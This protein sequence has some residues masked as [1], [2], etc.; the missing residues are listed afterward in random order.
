M[1]RTK[2]GNVK[3]VIDGR[4]F[5]SQKEASRYQELK[6]LEAAGEITHL[7]LQPTFVLMDSFT[8]H[9]KKH[10]EI[11]YRADFHYWDNR[12]QIEVVE[13]V[14]SGPT[15]TEAY[16]MRKKMFIRRYPEILFRE[17]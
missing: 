3:R 6:L 10:R 9:G 14:K 15:R 13:D 7:S 11:T 2:Y 8:V 12:E 16:M 1:T 4:I 5:D 17:T